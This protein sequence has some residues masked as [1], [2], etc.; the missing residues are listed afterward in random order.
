ME[1][2]LYIFRHGQTDFNLHNIWQGCRCN[3]ELNIVGKLQAMDLG[4]QLYPLDLGI[5][6]SSPLKRA[7][8]TA[9]LAAARFKSL[10]RIEIIPNLREG[11]FGVAEGRSFEQLGK[12]YPDLLEDILNP[13]LKNWDAAFPGDDSESKHQ[14]FNRVI[15][16]LGEIV[17][18]SSG[19]IGVSTHGGVISALTCGLG[20]RNVSFENYAVLHLKYDSSS[21]TFSQAE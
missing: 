15:G 6:Y 1:K 4:E 18:Y 21:R 13:T 10:P 2:D 12:D 19:N 17:R 11:N 20:L 8:Q 16:A 5:I 7:L 14:I 3:L 9:N